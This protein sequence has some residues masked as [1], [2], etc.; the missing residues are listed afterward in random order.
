MGPFLLGPVVDKYAVIKAN[1][2]LAGERPK[3]IFENRI[4]RSVYR[5]VAVAMK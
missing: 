2:V 5:C 4:D 1:V 3:D